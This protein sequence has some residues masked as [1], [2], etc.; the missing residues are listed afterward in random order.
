[1]ALKLVNNNKK[2]YRDDC[3]LFDEGNQIERRHRLR[4]CGDVDTSWWKKILK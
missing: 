2:L 1:M 3:V 4:W